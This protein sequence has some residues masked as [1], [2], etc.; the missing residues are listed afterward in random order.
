MAKKALNA[1]LDIHETYA[2]SK[3]QY[4]PRHLISQPR[5]SNMS[6]VMAEANFQY[7]RED[8]G[9]ELKVNNLAFVQTR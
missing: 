6:P 2:Q 5:C 4:L 8:V 3:Y 1:A 7:D 9:A